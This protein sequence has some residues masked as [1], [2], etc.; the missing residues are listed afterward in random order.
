MSDDLKKGDA[1]ATKNECELRFN[2]DAIQLVNNV[3]K[4]IT[5]IMT[6]LIGRGELIATATNRNKNKTKAK[7]S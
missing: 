5:S 1:I 2:L 4:Q 7:G 3:L 6:S